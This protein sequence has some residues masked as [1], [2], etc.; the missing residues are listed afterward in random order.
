MCAKAQLLLPYS[1]AV[2]RTGALDLLHVT[3]NVVVSEQLWGGGT[4]FSVCR[5][6]VIATQPEEQM[7]PTSFPPGF[8][9]PGWRQLVVWGTPLPEAVSSVVGH[10]TCL[11][12]PPPFIETTPLFSQLPPVCFHHV[13]C[14]FQNNFNTLSTARVMETDMSEEPCVRYTTVS[15]G[16]CC[17]CQ[18]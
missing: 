6:P 7:L 14:H 9:W 10:S 12:D 11:K 17:S 5:A 13:F 15:T 8:V 4:R 2:F 18:E 3:T 1:V 16:L